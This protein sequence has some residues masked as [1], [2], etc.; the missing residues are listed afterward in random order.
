MLIFIEDEVKSWRCRLTKINHE[1]QMGTFL[2]GKLRI[3]GN[4]KGNHIHTPS[5]SEQST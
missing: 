1:E 5:P 4:P 2:G 3:Q